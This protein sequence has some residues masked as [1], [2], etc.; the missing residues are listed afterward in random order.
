MTLDI[1]R[2]FWN[3]RY[4]SLETGWDVGEIT[5]PIKE[6][7]NQLS[8]KKMKILIP[9]C[10]NSYEAEYLFKNN[11]QNISLLDYSDKALLN[12]IERVPSFPKDNLL[13]INFFDC[14]GKFDLIIEQ[15]FFCAINK[16]KRFEY[17]KKMYDLLNVN[18]KLIGL[19]FD[20]VLNDDKPPFGGTKDEYIKYFKPYFNLV[21]FETAYNSILSRKGREL[22]IILRKKKI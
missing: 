7:V 16:K 2:D 12:F 17:V 19:L 13:N 9:G 3:E 4:L 1:N 8:D 5:T 20:D 10:G 14:K 18:G 21:V 11:F 15:T 6:Y 22:F